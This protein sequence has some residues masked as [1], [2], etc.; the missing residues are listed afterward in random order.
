MKINKRKS[1]SPHTQ[2]PRNPF[3]AAALLRKAGSHRRN[4]KSVRA[5]QKQNTLRAIR[6]TDSRE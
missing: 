6:E 1:L 2:Q 5:Q 4:N 3:V